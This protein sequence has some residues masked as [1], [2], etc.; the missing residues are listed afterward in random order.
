MV[1]DISPQSKQKIR[2]KQRSKIVKIYDRVY[3]ETSFTVVKIEL[4][5][6]DSAGLREKCYCSVIR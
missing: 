1:F 5:N 6:Q 2:S 4:T 3:I